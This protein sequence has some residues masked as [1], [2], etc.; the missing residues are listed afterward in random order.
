MK[1]YLKLGIACLI[2]VAFII[3]VKAHRSVPSNSLLL[4]NIE[5]LAA[6]ESVDA[7]CYGSGIVDCPIDHSKVKYVFEP[8]SL[9]W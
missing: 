2:V 1:N 4:D 7:F 5:A 6:D 8:Y 9:G 3:S